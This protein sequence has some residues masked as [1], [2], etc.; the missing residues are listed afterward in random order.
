[1]STLE[2][3]SNELIQQWHNL[4]FEMETTA[5]TTSELIFVKFRCQI[6]Q[7]QYWTTSF[8]SWHRQ[9][10]R[11]PLITKIIERLFKW[12]ADEEWCQ[13]A[14]ECWLTVIMMMTAVRHGGTR[15][16]PCARPRASPS[17]QLSGI[18]R[19]RIVRGSNHAIGCC[20]VGGPY[21]NKAINRPQPVLPKLSQDKE[22][23]ERMLVLEVLIFNEF[24]VPKASW[25]AMRSAHFTPLQASD[26]V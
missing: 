19:K 13:N 17:E 20:E 12:M 6:S 8:L 3:A 26:R 22:Q 5:L 25:A 10:K 16:D 18:V 7:P 9:K 24:L 11:P 4:V 21:L 1:M 23:T 15:E 14:W 2:T